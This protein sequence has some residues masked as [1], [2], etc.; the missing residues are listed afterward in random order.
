[1]VRNLPPQMK[2]EHDDGVSNK[3]SGKDKPYEEPSLAVIQTENVFNEFASPNLSSVV[4][5]GMFFSL[6]QLVS[7][8]EIADRTRIQAAPCDLA[9]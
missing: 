6:S 4:A 2:P 8:V 9:R 3:N 5:L 1:M 7:I